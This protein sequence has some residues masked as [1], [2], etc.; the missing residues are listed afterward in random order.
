M[1]CVSCVSDGLCV[2]SLVTLVVLCVFH[3]LR[4]VCSAFYVCVHADVALREQVFGEIE[5]QCTASNSLP[6]QPGNQLQFAHVTT[7]QQMDPMRGRPVANSENSDLIR[8]IGLGCK[9][10]DLQHA[11]RRKR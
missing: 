1:I 7:A 9:T 4:F 11:G 3:L 10:R 6:C 5:I 2:C 8:V